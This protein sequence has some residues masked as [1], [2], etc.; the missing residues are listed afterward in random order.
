MKLNYT[1]T[2]L[3]FLSILFFQGCGSS[4]SLP[5]YS[6][7]G[8]ESP[9]EA[10]TITPKKIKFNA[11]KAK[12]IELKDGSSL[13]I[14]KDAFVDKNGKLVEGEV[15]LSYRQYNDAADIIASGIPMQYQTPNGTMQ[16]LESAG[17]FE[18][19][20]T[21]NGKPIYIAPDKSIETNLASKQKGDYDFYYLNPK[22]EKDSE[23]GYNWEKL[24]NKADK[25][26]SKPIKGLD[27]FQL[28]LNTKL[29]PEL[30]LL[31]DIY[32]QLAVGDAEF[33]PKSSVNSIFKDEVWNDLTISQPKFM[34]KKK[35]TIPDGQ[36]LSKIEFIG[37]KIIFKGWGEFR[38]FDKKMQKVYEGGKIDI[39]AEDLLLVQDNDKNYTLLSKELKTLQKL[40]QLE[41]YL[42]DDKT[43]KLA[44]FTKNTENPLF[45]DL[46]ITDK[47]G[48]EQFRKTYKITEE[49]E[50]MNL[51][52]Q[53]GKIVAEDY[54]KVDIL[55]WDGS[56]INS[57]DKIE[58]KAAETVSAG[59]GEFILLAKNETSDYQMVA[60]NWKKN[61][62]YIAEEMNSFFASTTDFHPT[63][64]IA[65]VSNIHQG[66]TLWDLD[67]QTLVILPKGY[68]SFLEEGTDLI[69]TRYDTIYCKILDLKGNI[70]IDQSLSTRDLSAGFAF[71]AKDKK[72]ILTSFSK[73]KKVKLYD[74]K[75]NLIKD[76]NAYNNKIKQASFWKEN[77]ILTFATDGELNF[78]DT[79]GKLLR[80][81]KIEEEDFNA[82][83][84]KEDSTR[85]LSY[86]SYI[87]YW[88][89]EGQL[90]LNFGRNWV[91][92][93]M[94]NT[95]DQ[96]I[97][98]TK[99]NGEGEHIIFD[100]STPTDSNVYQ[101]TLS[102]K[103]NSLISYVY[104]DQATMRILDDYNNKRKL[105]IAKDKKIAEV[106]AV[107][108][109][110][111]IRSFSINNFGIYNWDR[112]YKNDPATQIQ[113]QASFSI[114][115]DKV[116]KNKTV[117]LITGEDRNA[118]IRYTTSTLDK[119][120]FDHSMYN[121]LFITLSDGR[122][123]IFEDESFKKLDIEKLKKTKKHYFKMKVLSRVSGL[124]HLKRLTKSE[125]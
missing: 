65:L 3:L 49:E 110:K 109:E 46:V 50:D 63:K 121:Q 43:K 108:D 90:L 89:M 123:A 68:S 6:Y 19:K 29:H 120:S 10:V 107:E 24:T 118:V 7:K 93:L 47:K 58:E 103:Q 97:G 16:Q 13:K 76:F 98:F 85:F 38:I 86:Q 92:G 67:Q 117:F 66:F 99:V 20:G 78:W 102:N 31:K 104:L 51:R 71:I 2:F 77:E 30:E 70:L 61:T 96:F 72:T 82:R 9:L 62:T 101:L 48:V 44:Y 1:L 54:Y 114:D 15:E 75:G 124:K 14:P 79:N 112:F 80:K 113:L 25:P 35:H 116:D 52:I 88:N 64:N 83:P 111:L 119:F 27:S 94:P 17:M 21:A 69:A 26:N 41:A 100:T 23:Q 36:F 11:N 4:S 60:W 87:K 33:N 122:I 42:Y 125:I 91:K 73:N 32:W 40:G 12:V 55:N 84:L 57:F 105:R 5:N 28:L 45:R 18:L 8:V 106:K 22:A 59:K 37:D 74:I 115:K 39:L 81:T 34:L 95:T 53:A 56:L